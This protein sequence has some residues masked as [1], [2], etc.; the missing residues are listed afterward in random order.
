M[1]EYVLEV[2]IFSLSSHLKGLSHSYPL[3]RRQVSVQRTLNVICSCQSVWMM[4]H[5][6]AVRHMQVTLVM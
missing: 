4:M 6:D 3:I 2:Y 1:Y 5:P